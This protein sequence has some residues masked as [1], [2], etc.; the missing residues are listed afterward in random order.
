MQ[1][2]VLVLKLRSDHREFSPNAFILAKS[3]CLYASFYQVVLL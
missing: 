1:I 3:N 2:L